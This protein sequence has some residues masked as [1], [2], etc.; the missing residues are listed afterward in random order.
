MRSRRAQVSRQPGRRQFKRDQANVNVPVRRPTLSDS[1]RFMPIYF[2]G[3]GV[4]VAGDGSG[5][6]EF[7]GVAIGGGGIGPAFS[8][9]GRP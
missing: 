8:I 6:A 5:V 9:V 4:G 7:V 2:G 3:S 1:I